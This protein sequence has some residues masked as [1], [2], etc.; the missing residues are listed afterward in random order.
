MQLIVLP[1]TKAS[2]ERS[3]TLQLGGLGSGH[4]FVT[5]WDLGRF[6]VTWKSVSSLKCDYE[7]VTYRALV[8]TEWDM[9]VQALGVRLV[10]MCDV[11]FIAIVVK[12]EKS[13]LLI[14]GRTNLFNDNFPVCLCGEVACGQLWSHNCLNLHASSLN[15][16]W[17]SHH[18]NAIGNMGLHW[19]PSPLSNPFS[20]SGLGEFKADNV[21][22]E[23][24]YPPWLVLD[25][26]G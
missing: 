20:Q 6:S 23:M 13:K 5:T 19:P 2:K 25:C 10:G 1:I 21:G 18:N 8:R 16:A 15:P 24:T 12:G 4:S 11:L 22:R 14:T 17:A 3:S 26:F 9:H 7:H